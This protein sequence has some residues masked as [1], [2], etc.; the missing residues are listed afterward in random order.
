[1]KHIFWPLC[2]LGLQGTALAASLGDPRLATRAP[3]GVVQVEPAPRVPIASTDPGFYPSIGQTSPES[4]PTER[5]R[6]ATVFQLILGGQPVPE[7][8]EPA[9]RDLRTENLRL[10]PDMS[11]LTRSA[12]RDTECDQFAA[13]VEEISLPW[14][15]SGSIAGAADI[16][17]SSAGDVGFHFTLTEPGGIT[18]ESCLPGTDFDT[19]VYLFRGDPCDGGTLILY[20]DGD[21][22]CATAW[23]AGWSL[24]L[25]LSAGDYTLV[26]TAFDDIVIG[27]Y[28]A[29][30]GFV[31]NPCPSFSCAGIAEI[32]PNDGP[33]SVPNIYQ[34]FNCEDT[35][36]GDTWA[37]NNFRDTDFYRINLLVDDSLHIDLQVYN[38]DAVLYL[39]DATNTILQVRDA[40]GFCRDEVLSTGCLDAGEYRIFVG[41]N[42]F[43]DIAAGS[44][45]MTVNCHPCSWEDPSG[46]D[47]IHCWQEVVATTTGNISHVGTNSP[48]T[49]FRYVVT[50]DELV[51]FSLCLTLP[52]WDTYLAVYDRYPPNYR[53][54]VNAHVAPL[55]SSLDDCGVLSETTIALSPVSRTAPKPGEYWVMV[56]GQGH[57]DQGQFNLIA[58]CLDCVEVPCNGPREHEPNGEPFASP[59]RVTPVD[60]GEPVCG[61][62]WASNGTRDTDWFRFTLD[63]RDSV[64]V[65][66]ETGLFDGVL[67]LLDANETFLESAD[68]NGYCGDETMYS[69]CLEPGTYYVF[70]AHNS[71]WGVLPTDYQVM[72]DCYPCTQEIH[73]GTE[74]VFDTSEDH[75]NNL[76]PDEVIF[77]D[78]QG[79]GNLIVDI[80]ICIGAVTPWTLYVYDRYPTSIPSPAH[81]YFTSGL[82]SCGGPPEVTL[83]LPV[84]SYYLVI[85]APGADAISGYAL[86]TCRD[87]PL[88]VCTGTLEQ[89]PNNGPYYLPAS[90][91]VIH[92]GEQICGSVYRMLDANPIHDED[93]FRLDLLAHS[94]VDIIL[95]TGGF[96]AQL[97]LVDLFG[98]VGIVGGSVDECSSLSLTTPCLEAGT[99]YVVVR[100]NWVLPLL[101]TAEYRLRVD[102]RLCD[103]SDSYEPCQFPAPCNT[104]WTAGT[105]EV[106]ANGLN[107]L[108]KEKFGSAGLIT[109]IDFRGIPA[110]YNGSTWGTCNQSPMPLEISFYDRYGVLADQWTWAAVGT[111]S[112]PL[113][114]YNGF[115]A[116]D[117]HFVL[118]TP[119]YLLSGYITIQGLT[120]NTCWFLWLSSNQG[121]GVSYIDVDGI[122]YAPVAYDLNYCLSIAQPCATPPV[123]VI[124]MTGVDATLFWAP[125][126]GAY[127]YAVYSATSSS[128]PWTLLGTTSLT[129][130]THTNAISYGMQIYHVRALCYP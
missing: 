89:E 69:G 100:T 51:N 67:Y 58:S 112:I 19:D 128:S 98:Q 42:G 109:A 85:D 104:S 78:Q 7:A 114:C 74:I 9:A 97:E 130:F 24:P 28:N 55:I 88:D 56:E 3:D 63:A 57:T 94:E 32:E 35:V 64:V 59:A 48:E 71:F 125:V 103:W 44:Y 116:F 20:N 91:G 66:L 86:I 12:S 108:R 47:T 79:P 80:R 1:M 127:G 6:R 129:A 5:E 106:D 33:N 15:G 122:T 22:D 60:C 54:P 118:P 65:S 16:L 37:L 73:C 77:F 82:T 8:L 81:L 92:C 62:T 50:A 105:S 72:I 21:P 34:N 90:E 123:A 31:P 61:S 40:E 41:H 23:A 26:L 101:T 43:N 110:Y 76:D 4:P 117:Y 18:L 107:Y 119:L 27:E 121:D 49:Y 11:R 45:A 115:P 38:F 99:Y 96:S 95:E 70:V 84:G 75:N 30:I 93:W 25:A 39:L 126:P 10:E 17:G 124:S 111:P 68:L 113:N 46:W 36:C 52:V 87:C 120:D 14:T 29:H 13:E 83:A 102:C 2:L 53:W